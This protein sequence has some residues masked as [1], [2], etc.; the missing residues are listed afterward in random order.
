MGKLVKNPNILARNINSVCHSNRVT[1]EFNSSGINYFDQDWDNL[2]IL[3]ACRADIFDE[4]LLKGEYSEKISLGSNTE[5][6]L[7]A[8]L[9]GRELHDTVYVTSNPMFYR[10]SDEINA[11]FHDTAEV[12]LEDGWDENYNTVLPETL[13]K[14]A[15]EFNDMYPNKR[16]VAHYI[17]P[18]YPFIDTDRDF[19]QKTPDPSDPQTDFWHE[20]MTGEIKVSPQSVEKSYRNNLS[21]VI[22]QVKSLLTELNGKTV[23]TSDH[24]NMLGEASFPLPIQEWGHPPMTYTSQLVRVPWVEITSGK[25]KNIIN[26]EPVQDRKSSDDDVVQSRLS[27]LGY[28]S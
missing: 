23:V 7:K 9:S 11:S 10:H 8:N 22:P 19:D 4:S 6:F 1:G 21:R 17:Q 14:F 28:I 3:D 15:K 27:D 2:I 12:W 16:L 5:Q 24:G 13:T 26:E 20:L 18:H 25:R